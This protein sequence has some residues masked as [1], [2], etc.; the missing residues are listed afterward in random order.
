MLYVTCIN[1]L[2]VS[3]S[4]NQNDCDVIEIVIYIDFGI[5]LPWKL[6]L[7]IP[8]LYMRA[9]FKCRMHMLSL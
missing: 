3:V 6:L 9:Q 2:P 1:P 8:R 7:I 4:V 5:V